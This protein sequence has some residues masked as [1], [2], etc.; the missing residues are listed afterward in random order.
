[1]TEI[2]SSH[3][4]WNFIAFVKVLRVDTASQ[5]QPRSTRFNFLA[6]I[7]D[8]VGF[9]LA[10][11]F[12]SVDS[13]MPSMVR[14]LTDSAPVI[15][16]VS[17]VFSGVWLLPQLVVANLIKDKPRKRPYL[18]APMI[19]RIG[20]VLIGLGLWAGLARSPVVMLVLFFV[21][22]V[23][24]SVGDGISNVAW[25]D[26]LARAL[27]VK[28]RGRLFG[29]GEALS[30]L[31]GIGVGLLVRNILG[32]PQ[33]VFPNN[34]ALLFGL[35]SVS[36]AI[37]AVGGILIQEPSPSTTNSQGDVQAGQHWSKLLVIDGA[38]RR[39]VICRLLVA[40]VGLA[41][42]FYV[43]Y[44]TDV[45][46]LP[47]SVIGSFVIAQTMGAAGASVLLVLVSE[48][49][50][51]RS[52]IHIGSAAGAIGPVFGLVVHF[53]DASWLVRAYPAV[54]VLLGVSNSIW[55]VGFY[56][57]LLEITPGRMRP[58]YLGTLSTILGLLALVP[59]LGGWLL[60]TTSY[61]V[62]FSATFILTA[63]GFLFSL[64]LKPPKA[65]VRS[66]AL[67]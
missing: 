67:K 18:I 26:I 54:F 12:V 22:I 29:I 1:M 4:R 16:S 30:G 33:I 45:L 46:S 19:G 7:V 38:F 62:L 31:L 20:F 65:I 36:M 21:S 66:G 11:A 50:G 51:P 23:M 49:W 9:M 52:V 6:F 8:F 37:S 61:A 48:H 53:V 47:Q 43:L 28:Q 27:P 55:G 64:T 17:M 3:S 24:F 34:Y 63:A 14:H 60:E 25:L 58:V 44:A 59:V 15:G 10:M 56:N 2:L 35:A 5:T 42:P 13:V 41:S 40:M 39:L 32:N 57:Y